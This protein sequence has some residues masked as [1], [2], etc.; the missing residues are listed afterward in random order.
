MYDLVFKNGL[1]CDGMGGEPYRGWVAVKEGKIAAV[2]TLEPPEG[3][4]SV[5]CGGLAVAP[6]F[7][8]IHSHSDAC[9][10]ADDACEAKLR[11]G[12]TTEVV[13][14]C[15]FSL[16]PCPSG[17]EGDL[18]LLSTGLGGGTADYVTTSFAR[19]R[20]KAYG[21]KMA[22]NLFQLIGHGALRAATV[23]FD[24]REPTDKELADMCALL[25][26][27][28]SEGTAGLSLGLGYAPGCFATKRELRALGEVVAKYDGVIT[29][30]M[31]NQS[32]KIPEALEE[33]YDINRH[34]GA[35]VHISHLK[36]ARRA[37]WGKA[38][39][40]MANIRHARADGVAVTAD[41]YPYTAAASGITNSGF[42]KWSLEG[43]VTAVC[44]RL[45][46]EER[47][48]VLSA[49]EEYYCDEAVG[50]GEVIV[51]TFG[52][53][54][55]ADGKSIYALSKE[56]GLTMAETAALVTVKTGADCSCI[57]FTM[58]EED[59]NYLLS[60][61]DL[62]IGSDGYAYPLDPAKNSGKPHPRSFGTFPRF[63]RLARDEKLC[64]L[65]LAVRRIT[66]LS[67]EMMGA[68]GRGKL[69]PGY[70][71][72][73]T[74]FNPETVSD[75]AEYDDPFRAPEGIVHVVM[76][77]DFALRDGSQTPARLGAYLLKTR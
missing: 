59:V 72:D 53:Y 42:P 67:A 50:R 61:P 31:R 43:G 28:L 65:G 76:A 20:E 11:Q 33:M 52:K 2:G 58:S 74:V 9:F 3:A 66:G 5:D 44:R 29:S 37:N 30:H 16:F 14:Q 60:Q 63:L 8:D 35:R 51:S 13:G 15:G 7:I 18:K 26:T 38:P 36:A 23:G 34:S 55:F 19:Y 46:N 21:R 71:A 57:S 68:L 27:A 77:G 39:M 56:L 6:G 10:L 4:E 47:D 64:P 1:V 70:A 17:R 54:P 41:L 40:V 22:T 69:I 24:G 45:Q 25:D 48:A 32:D 12:V 75:R 73:L 62:A 49:L